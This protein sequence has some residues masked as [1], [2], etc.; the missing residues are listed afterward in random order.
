MEKNIMK[1]F[2]SLIGLSWDIAKNNTCDI[3]MTYSEM[4]N[5]IKVSNSQNNVVTAM[6]TKEDYA[7]LWKM[8]N[9]LLVPH[10]MK[11]TVNGK[12]IS[13]RKPYKSFTVN[14]G[15]TNVDM[16][17]HSGN[18]YDEKSY[19][20][21]KGIPIQIIDFP[22]NINIHE[23]IPIDNAHPSTVIIDVFSKALDTALPD[24]TVNQTLKFLSFIEK[25]GLDEL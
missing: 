4:D 14:D 9:R 7:I 1:L 5:E 3:E 24:L 16:V 17:P 21:E 12:V 11:F 18:E 6:G 8:F 19:L 20:Y 23:S 2:G 15:K 22:W 25:G 13:Y 10:G